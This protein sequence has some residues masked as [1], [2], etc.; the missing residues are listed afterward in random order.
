MSTGMFLLRLALW[1]GGTL[2]CA[3]MFVATIIMKVRG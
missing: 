2:V 1:G 3:A